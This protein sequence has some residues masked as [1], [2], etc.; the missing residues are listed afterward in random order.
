MIYFVLQLQTASGITK[1]D[2]LLL[3][4]FSGITKCD[5]IY[6]KLRQILQSKTFIIKSDIIEEIISLKRCLSLTKS[7]LITLAPLLENGIIIIGCRFAM[8]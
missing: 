5:R 7:N 4:N 6:Y 1:Y 8:L 3:Q 2:R